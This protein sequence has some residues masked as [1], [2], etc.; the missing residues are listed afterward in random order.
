MSDRILLVEDDIS[1]AGL[2]RDYL[3]IDGFS[4]EHAEDGH[5]GLELA[6]KESFN[7]ILLDVMLP[8]INGFD[9]CRKIRHQSDVPLL[10]ISARKEDIDKIRGLGLGADD[11]VT[12]PFSPGELVARVKAH[13][14]RYN[15][16]TSENKPVR[17]N[18]ITLRNLMLDI[19]S[20]RAYIKKHEVILTGK[21]FEMLHLFMRH[22]DRVF[23]KD[24]IFDRI[25][26]EDTLGDTTTVTVHVRKIREKIEENPSDPVYLETVWGMGYRL[27]I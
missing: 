7:L 11:Y 27:R 8:G 12:K 5:S 13:I 26:G 19:D 24:E 18:Q 14:R 1:I 16:L 4:V 23:S 3:E 2:I 10:L 22:P 9:I 6:L 15:R 25:W 20:R 17:K 21:E